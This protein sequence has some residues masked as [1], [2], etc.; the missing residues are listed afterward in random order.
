[1]SVTGSTWTLQDECHP[2][3]ILAYTHN[4]WFH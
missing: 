2:H 3:C 4:S 1:M